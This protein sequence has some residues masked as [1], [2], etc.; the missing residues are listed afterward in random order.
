MDYVVFLY[1]FLVL[2][3]K[4]VRDFLDAL[5]KLLGR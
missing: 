2:I 3:L 5:L 4:T 1:E